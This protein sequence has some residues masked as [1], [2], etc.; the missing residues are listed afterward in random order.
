MQKLTAEM[1]VDQLV[2]SDP[3]ISPDGALVAFVAAP[4]GRRGEH[5]PRAPC[6]SSRQTARPRR[7]G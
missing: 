5:T 6:G 7:A 4:M 2:P 1:I 3:R